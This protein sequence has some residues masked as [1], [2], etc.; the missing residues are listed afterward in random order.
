MSDQVI[1]IIALV[2]IF[3]VATFSAVHLGVLAIVAAF[4]VGSTVAEESS[5]DIFAGFPGD[6]FVVLVGVTLLFGIAK[7]NGTVDWLIDAAVKAVRGRIAFIPWVMFLVTAVLTAVGAVTPAAVGIVA[8]I[9]LGFAATYGI[10]PVLM[11]LFIANGASAGGF[12]PIGVFG[13]ITNNVVERNDLPGDPAL[14]FTAS[15]LF[16]VGLC[17]IVFLLFGG[18]QLLGRIA[19]GTGK[20]ASDAADG[21][22]PPEPLRLDLPR[23]LTLL[24]LLSLVAGALFFDLDVGLMALTIA[25]VL[26]LVAPK[27]AKGAVDRCAWSTVLLV[28]GIVTYVSQM[29]RIGTI[30]F[31]GER[32]ASIDAPL[33]GALLICLIGAVVSAFASTT[34]MLGA[35]IPL[36]VPFLLTGQVGAVG[37][38][39]ALA[40]SASIVDASPFSTS[41][42]LVTANTPADQRELVFRRLMAWGLGIAL[43]GPLVT[44]CLFVVPGSL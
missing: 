10:S 13:S 35:L 42:A 41:G 4:I 16:N 37:L 29:E 36:A 12:S 15:F 6:L 44:W 30:D 8:P 3:A 33:L 23:A 34:G 21:T 20:E 25:V 32:V 22:T 43:V 5:D 39:T 17:V 28:C 38:I 2:L 40:I 18:R 9:G 27:S 31:L 1:S 19:T 14:L 7:S 11:G 26:S 24:G